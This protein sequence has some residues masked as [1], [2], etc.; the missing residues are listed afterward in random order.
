MITLHPILDTQDL[1]LT[2]MGKEITYRLFRGPSD[3]VAMEAVT[4][5]C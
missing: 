1:P 4:Q 2:I 5:H 3:Y